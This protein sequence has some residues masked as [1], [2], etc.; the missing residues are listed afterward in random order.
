MAGK[1]FKFGTIFSALSIFFLFTGVMLTNFEKHR[2]HSG[3]VFTISGFNFVAALGCWIAYWSI[4]IKLDV[5]KD[6][7]ETVVKEREEKLRL[8]IDQQRVRSMV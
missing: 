7:I 3:L 4:K 6:E 8:K 2:T 5:D 1:L